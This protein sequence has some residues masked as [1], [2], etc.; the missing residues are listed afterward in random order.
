M[1]FK[2]ESTGKMGFL[3]ALML[4]VFFVLR[5]FSI[6]FVEGT[7]SYWTTE[8][9]DI[10]QYFAGFN[11]FFNA[12]FE[13]P[14]LAFDSI[15]YPQGTRVTFVDAIPLY[16]FIL[17]LFVPAS[18]APFNP[19]GV[20]VA[21]C[22]I[23]Q[24]IC[25]WWILRE[26]KIH[27]WF[28]LFALAIVFLTFPALTTRLG[29]ISL[30]SHWII[31]S[32]LALYIRSY[33]LSRVELLGWAF[34]LFSSFYINIYLFV[35]ASAIYVA[36]TF[37][38]YGLI[39]CRELLR[40]SIPFILIGASLFITIF[41]LEQVEVAKETGFGVYSMNL[42]SPFH[43]GKYINFPSPEMPG[44]YEGF[45]YLGLGVLVSFVV[46]LLLNRK[47]NQSI[48]AK[49]RVITLLMILFTIY[50]L[51]NVIYLGTNEI[52]TLNYPAFM[53]HITSQFRA[54]GRFFWPVGYCVVI[55]SIIVLYRFL[56]GKFFAVAM[57]ALIVVQWSDLSN[58]RHRLADTAKRP[59]TTVLT[60]SVWDQYLNESTKFLYFFPKFRCGRADQILNT[61][62]PT[63][64]YASMNNLK[65]NTGYVARSSSNCSVEST[66]SEI[67][68]SQ[69]SSSLYIFNRGDFDRL[70]TVRAL[71]PVERLPVC[72]EVDFAY[73]CTIQ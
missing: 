10:T 45:N 29:H 43:G 65:I 20:W 15:N 17:K 72:K 40:A 28:A 48:F 9:E 25:G 68:S 61:L 1:H 41:P 3:F 12:P 51:S 49:N 14:L 26:L 53:S 19:F 21:F 73:F 36:C 38:I 64:F 55:I 62:M 47:A 30:M 37:Q 57:L 46:S 34:L 44:Q 24:A 5:Y 32:A 2:L 39:S 60:H 11:A 18:F 66:K 22:F 4:G 8:V 33:R 63:M 13:F 6:G 16:S 69:A 58:L 54:S 7:S 35:M 23:G 67:A 70:E 56:S 71:F 52:L 27:S 31:L 42:L 59:A 50:A